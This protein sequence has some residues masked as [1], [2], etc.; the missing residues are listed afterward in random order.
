LGYNASF[1]WIWITKRG[2]RAMPMFADGSQGYL[3]TRTE[4][5][6]TKR[7]LPSIASAAISGCKW[8]KNAMAIAA[9]LYPKAQKR[10]WRMTL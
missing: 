7:L 10:F 6:R 9:A 3:A 2:V 8:P 5:L 4:L 1:L